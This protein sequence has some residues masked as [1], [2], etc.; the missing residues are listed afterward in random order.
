M[1][2]VNVGI[3]VYGFLQGFEFLQEYEEGKTL[4]FNEHYKILTLSDVSGI[5]NIKSIIIK[6]SRAN[7]GK[8]IQSMH[9][10]TNPEKNNRLLNVYK[11]M[12][13]FKI[14]GLITIGGDDTLKT[15]N[16][17]YLMQYHVPYQTNAYCS[18]PENLDN[19]TWGLMAFGSPRRTISAAANEN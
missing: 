10:L 9:D 7:P 19:A 6:T 3:E 18:Y 1:N 15:A 16:Y 8:G 2:L 14:D 17:L 5:R 11:W 12:D 4:A 13:Y